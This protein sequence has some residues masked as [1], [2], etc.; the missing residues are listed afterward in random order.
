MRMPK[1]IM[2]AILALVEITEFRL[3]IRKNPMQTS[4]NMKAAGMNLNH[5][6]PSM[7]QPHANRPSGSAAA[8]QTNPKMI[9]SMR[10]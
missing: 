10:N 4:P 8:R 7:K 9:F 1:K 6:A 2:I 3:K 5:N